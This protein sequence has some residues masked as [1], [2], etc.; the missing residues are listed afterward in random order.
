MS[1]KNQKLIGLWLTPRLENML[2]FLAISF[3]DKGYTKSTSKQVALRYMI[4]K[5]YLADQNE[6]ARIAQAEA[7]N[8]NYE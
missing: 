4:E 8:N 6:L 1:S 2:E 5:K 3:R 7:K